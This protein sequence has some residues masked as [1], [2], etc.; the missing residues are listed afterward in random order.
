MVR[1]VVKNTSSA[2]AGVAPSPRPSIV[3]A[4][5]A[6]PRRTVDAAAG[7]FRPLGNLPVLEDLMTIHSPAFYYDILASRAKRLS[8]WKTSYFHVMDSHQ[9]I[10]DM[11]STT[12]MK[13]FLD[14]L[15]SAGEKTAFEADVLS[16]LKKA[17]E[18][19]KDGKVL[20]PFERL[21]FIAY[22]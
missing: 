22:T 9:A 14:A 12:G 16:E 11:V 18:S 21:F 20:F 8:F 17:Y 3:S 4:S 13:P 7:H 1:P 2:R 19:R 6:T 15:P 5:A 10:I